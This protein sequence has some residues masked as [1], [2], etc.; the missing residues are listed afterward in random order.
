MQRNAS[1]NVKVHVGVE[2]QKH[3]NGQHW[4]KNRDLPCSS[5]KLGLTFTSIFFAIIITYNHPID[6]I[7][8]QNIKIELHS[9][10]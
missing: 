1:T 3:Y 9:L 2:G 8:F 5:T 10:V 7:L 4:E 6:I